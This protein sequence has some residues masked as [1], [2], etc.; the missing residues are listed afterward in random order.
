MSARFERS[1]DGRQLV[2]T[3]MGPSHAR[4]IAVE[5]LDPPIKLRGHPDLEDIH[6]LNGG[7]YR[8]RAYVSWDTPPPVKVKMVWVDSRGEQSLE[9]NVSL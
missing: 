3:N 1:I 7:E 8:M 4:L 2:V 6:L 9:Q 5:V